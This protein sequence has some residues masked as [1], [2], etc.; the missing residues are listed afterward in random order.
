MNV[1]NIYIIGGGI[2]GC[3]TAIQLSKRSRSLNIHLFEKQS[4]ILTGPPFCHLHAGG[5][6]YPMISFQ[7]SEQ[8][9]YDSL[10]FAGIFNDCLEKRPT[11]IAYKK[12]TQYNIGKLILK[13]KMMKYCYTNWSKS[14]AGKLPIGSIDNYFEMYTRED[15]INFKNG[16]RSIENKVHDPYVEKF[17]HYLKNVDDIQ[18][19]FISVNE[20]GINLESVKCKI[21]SI[22]K[23]SDN[24]F[25]YTNTQISLDNLVNNDQNII[26]NA[27]G[28]NTNSILNLPNNNDY[29]LELKSSWVI[30]NKIEIDPYFPEIAIIGERN[31]PNGMLQI[32]PL[33]NNCYQ[34]HCMKDDITLFSNGCVFSDKISEF[35]KQFNN[36]IQNNKFNEQ[37]IITRTSNAQREICKLFNGFDNSEI[38]MNPLWGIQRIPGNINSKRNWSVLQK[39]NY[40]EIHLVKGISS[41]SV[42]KQINNMI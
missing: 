34:I 3:V 7:E 21:K 41:I 24:I 39:K 35:Y 26:I 32:T 31:T 40:I 23:N 6:L 9:L 1:K 10:E 25:L 33:A 19:P 8:L 14:N 29:F 2:S 28:Y 27:A 36:I 13:C 20:Y 16:V 22:I 4:D 38:V 17:A 42:A 37:I 5:M 15:L 30:K 12:N 18:Y 11:I